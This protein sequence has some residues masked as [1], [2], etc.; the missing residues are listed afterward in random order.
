MTPKNK[1]LEHVIESCEHE[2]ES[3][4][5]RYNRL[6][7]KAQQTCTFAS[8]ILGFIITLYSSDKNK[9]LIEQSYLNTVT[10]LLVIMLLFVIVLCM[11]IMKVYSTLEA[12]TYEMLKKEFLELRDID[13]QD[14]SFNNIDN[15]LNM[16]IDFWAIAL[17]SV[18]KKNNLKAKLLY[19]AQI[20]LLLC[21]IV[22]CLCFMFSI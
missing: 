17:K 8:V 20:L 19:A 22:I 15:F 1:L 21:I 4:F 6:D 18:N 7:N 3:K 2:Y 14:L 11:F 16:K 12:P 5:E 10:V 13:N 9:L